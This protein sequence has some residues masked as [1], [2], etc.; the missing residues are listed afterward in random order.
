MPKIKLS[1]KMQKKLQNAFN[2]LGI[3]VVGGF[4]A[5][6]IALITQVQ[7]PMGEESKALKDVKKRK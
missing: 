2:V 4:T 6:N 5:S 3:M 1:A 7:I